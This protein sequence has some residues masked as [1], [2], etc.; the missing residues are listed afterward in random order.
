MRFESTHSTIDARICKRNWRKLAE[1]RDMPL[2]PTSSATSTSLW[3]PRAWNKDLHDD[4]VVFDL[5]Y[6]PLRLTYYWLFFCVSIEIKRG[7]CLNSGMRMIDRDK[8]HHQLFD[9]RSNEK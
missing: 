2:K 1:W 6:Y 9:F 4:E 3:F 5:H 8:T 7:R